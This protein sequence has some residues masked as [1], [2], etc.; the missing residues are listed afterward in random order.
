MLFQEALCA[1]RKVEDGASKEFGCLVLQKD[2]ESGIPVFPKMV[3][4]ESV[5]A[6]DCDSRHDS[7][8]GICDRCG[9]AP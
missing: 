7:I 8:H 5:P 1:G 2:H 6:A 4:L 9:C 3:S